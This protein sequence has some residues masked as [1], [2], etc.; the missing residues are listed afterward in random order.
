MIMFPINVR[1]MNNDAYRPMV[2]R[3]MLNQVLPGKKSKCLRNEV[4]VYQ[5]LKKSIWLYVHLC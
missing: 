4:F 3:S 2:K 1:G 5:M